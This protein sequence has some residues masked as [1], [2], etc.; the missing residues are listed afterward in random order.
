MKPKAKTQNSANPPSPLTDH[1][2]NKL[3]WGRYQLKKLLGQG[4]AG[5][6]YRAH[7]NLLKRDV[8]I[9][10]I[11]KTK[12]AAQSQSRSVTV[13]EE[14][15]VKEARVL[16]QLNHPSI[17]PIY[18]LNVPLEES[19]DCPLSF[20][21]EEIQGA[22]LDQLMMKFH[23]CSRH[24]SFVIFRELMNIVIS[25]SKAVGWAHHKGIIH[26]DLKPSNIIVGRFGEVKVIDWGLGKLG[27]LKHSPS[28]SEEVD[29]LEENSS[30]HS[31]D[32]YDLGLTFTGR[33][34][35]T[36]LYMSPEQ[37]RLEPLDPRADVYSIGAI[38]YH[39]LTG[40][41]QH[42]SPQSQISDP[43]VLVE[44]LAQDRIPTPIQQMRGPH[45][46]LCSSAMIDLC[47]QAMNIDREKRFAAAE[48]VLWLSLS[49]SMPFAGCALRLPC[50]LSWP[51]P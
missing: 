4:G 2:S 17:I 27:D 47:E 11:K 48:S 49:R 26:R 5:L 18:D 13:A 22:T 24:E 16:A 50:V 7:D 33:L 31:R 20:T 12:T 43:Y 8:A 42:I 10:F 51:F 40:F 3:L 6:V 34:S 32:P 35:G 36:P 39:I 1:Q 19:S 41:P 23:Q 29:H 46:Y 44:L 38:L 37:A 9:K 28:Q 45:P 15:F 14:A 21:M 30:D 25:V